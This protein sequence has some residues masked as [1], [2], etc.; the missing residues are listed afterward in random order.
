MINIFGHVNTARWKGF[1]SSTT[2]MHSSAG[3]RDSYGLCVLRRPISCLVQGKK[4]D[5]PKAGIFSGCH[6][7]GAE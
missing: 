6:F 4:R 5:L 1:D 2:P 7:C 3:L